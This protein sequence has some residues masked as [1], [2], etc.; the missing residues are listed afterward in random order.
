MKRCICNSLFYLMGTLWKGDL[1]RV[2]RWPKKSMRAHR[3]ATLTASRAPEQLEDLLQF[4]YAWDPRCLN[5][6]WSRD[7]KLI[8]LTCL[9]IGA[10]KA[11]SQIWSDISMLL[12]CSQRPLSAKMSVPLFKGERHFILTAHKESLVALSIYQHEHYAAINR[13]AHF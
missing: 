11:L 5:S 1:R 8:P 3:Q 13:K 9:T 6:R 4:V 12:K 10:P 7:T 2:C